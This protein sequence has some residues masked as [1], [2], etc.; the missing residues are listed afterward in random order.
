MLFL[1]I[2]L[3]CQC[4]QC[5][6]LVLLVNREV[7]LAPYLYY[8]LHPLVSL[9]N[10][11]IF[12]V[13]SSSYTKHFMLYCL[14]NSVNYFIVYSL[15]SKLDSE[16]ISIEFQKLPF[17]VDKYFLCILCFLCLFFSIIVNIYHSAFSHL[18]ELN[19]YAKLF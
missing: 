5:L 3:Q 1:P 12:N 10:M 16:K 13:P 8:I 11:Y 19:K 15:K 4:Q 18:L 17:S 7:S 9:N 2:F 14:R 6:P